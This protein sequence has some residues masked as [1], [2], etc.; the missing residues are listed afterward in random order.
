MTDHTHQNEPSD[1]N[2]DHAHNIGERHVTTDHVAT[3]QVNCDT[4]NDVSSEYVTVEH[5]Q[6]N[7]T[8]PSHAHRDICEND[9]LRSTPGDQ[10]HSRPIA[11][12]NLTFEQITTD[13]AHQGHVMKD[14]R[15]SQREVREHNVTKDRAKDVQDR[16]KS[17]HA[18][19][20]LSHAYCR[21]VSENVNSC[22][23]QIY[24]SVGRRYRSEPDHVSTYSAH[25]GHAAGDHA[26]S[27]HAHKVRECPVVEDRSNYRTQ[28]GVSSAQMGEEYTDKTRMNRR[29]AH[30]DVTSYSAQTTA[31]D[32]PVLQTSEHVTIDSASKGRVTKD[33][34][35]SG[36]THNVKQHV[37]SEKVNRG[38]QDDV[39]SEQLTAGNAHQRHFNPN[40]AYRAVPEN[41]TLFSGQNRGLQTSEHVT[42]DSAYKGRVTT[43][44]VNSGHTHNANQQHVTKQ[45]EASEK[46]NHGV[47][48]DSEH[49]TADNAHKSHVN[50][51]HA[52]QSV[53]ENVTLFC[54]QNGGPD[55][56]TS[57]HHSHSSVPDHVTIDSAHK[58]HV[59]SEHVTKASFTPVHKSGVLVHLSEVYKRCTFYPVC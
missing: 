43:A 12:A 55:S 45:H 22:D 30:R 10:S 33:E 48:D 59:I 5:A 52:Y 23:G 6:K 11:P 44:D 7:Y 47:Q 1:V 32:L 58:D 13:S 54:G 2:A 56:M 19:V 35:N 26:N 51:N 40:H 24:R 14:G 57:V 4:R 46:V 9:T 8:N 39:Y 20:N 50:P 37:A 31:P 21:D 42:T 53:P 3:D 41:V 16:M 36:H 28:N 38:V 15:N 18:Q 25:K 34:V 17:D 29:H 27:D 49:V